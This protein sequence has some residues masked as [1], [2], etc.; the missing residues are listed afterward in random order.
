MQQ[1]SPSASANVRIINIEKYIFLQSNPTLF[2]KYNFEASIIMCIY[3]T[4]MG[5]SSA[6]PF[7]LVA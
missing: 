3:F 6:L 1:V 7:F 5:F 2:L 4:N